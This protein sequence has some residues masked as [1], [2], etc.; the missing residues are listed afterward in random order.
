MSNSFVLM[1]WT[2]TAGLLTGQPWTVG[3]LAMAVSATVLVSATRLVMLLLLNPQN[4][5]CQSHSVSVA[6]SQSLTPQI[7]VTSR[8]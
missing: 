6:S 5:T 4:H 8:K 1:A 7:L 2:W 3:L